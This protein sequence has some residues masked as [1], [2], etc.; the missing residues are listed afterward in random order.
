MNPHD[1]ELYSKIGKIESLLTANLEYMKRD[2]ND[3]KSSH[4]ELRSLIKNDRFDIDKLKEGSTIS[5]SKLREILNTI[6]DF[7]NDLSVLENTLRREFSDNL[8]MSAETRHLQANTNLKI[9]GSI[10]A[11]IGILAEI[12]RRSGVIELNLTP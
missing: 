1:T 3:L 2:L 12:L 6:E 9:A 10:L 4:S 7:K 8:G 5:N 11:G